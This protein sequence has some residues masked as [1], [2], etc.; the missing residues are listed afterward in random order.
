V[1]KSAPEANR[2]LRKPLQ[3]AVLLWFAILTALAAQAQQHPRLEAFGGF[4]YANV[5]LGS[6]S[7]L[8]APTGRNYYGGGFS[9]SFNPKA[10]LRVILLDVGLESG[11]SAFPD[12]GALTTG[13]LLV[14]PEFVLRRRHVNGFAHTLFGLAQYDLGSCA[15]PC[16]FPYT[17]PPVLT[18]HA[19]VRNH[20]AMGLGAGLDINLSHYFAMRLIQA[21]YVPTR[22]LG[23]WESS[24]RIN[25]GVV[26][27]AAYTK[28]R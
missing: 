13:Q 3:N 22:I 1:I 14:G 20:F 18:P 12:E 21:D 24:F 5:N 28:P 4:S 15:T 8:F 11:H 7:S 19:N 9:F 23:Y 6:E 25:T 17:P 26:F 10:Y 2:E 27:R 16:A